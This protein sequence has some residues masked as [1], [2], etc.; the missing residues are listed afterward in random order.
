MLSDAFVDG[1]SVVFPTIDVVEGDRLSL[2]ESRVEVGHE[3]EV[4]EL[5]KNLG[6]LMSIRGMVGFCRRKM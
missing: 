5:K 4:V 2:V 1:L 6:P 3:P